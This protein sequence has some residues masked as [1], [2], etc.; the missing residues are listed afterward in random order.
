[1]LFRSRRLQLMTQIVQN[2]HMCD[3]GTKEYL[4]WNVRGPETDKGKQ[5]RPGD[6]KQLIG[7]NY[8]D[9]ET[10]TLKTI[11]GDEHYLI[12]KTIKIRSVLHC[13]HPDPSGI[14]STCFGELSLSV[15]E[16]TNIGQMCCTSLAQ[17]S[18]QKVISIK[19][20]DG[21]SVVDGI[22]LSS[23]DKQFLKVAVDDNSYL[24]AERLKSLDTKMIIRSIEANNIT[25]VAHVK[26]V[27]DLNIT[28]ISELT[29]ITF[30]TKVN[31]A[32]HLDIVDVNIGR[33]LASMTYDLL[34]YVKNN[35][36]DVDSDGNFI[37]D[38]KNWDWSKTILTLPLRH[39][40]MSDHNAEIADMIESSV[41]NMQERDSVVSPDA[42]IVEFFDLVN[43]KLN[44]NLAPLEVVMYA[45]MIVS[46]LNGDYSLPK[47]WTDKGLGI[48][49]LTIPRRSL[50]AAYAYEYHRQTIVNAAS[51]FDENRES[52]VM[53]AFIC[54]QEVIDD[55]ES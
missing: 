36:W 40:N 10:N 48:T 13:A 3:C 7:K 54:P 31:D 51:F 34:D 14:C 52:H 11:T 21:S 8:L 17:K 20:L 27:I 43:L 55:L 35:G 1:M 53:D 42:A 39:F 37:I 44:V 41:D 22:V 25:D 45:T 38:M 32:V 15:P 26:D 29:A 18:S 30:Q 4:L 33:R 2:L 19:H 6:L 46:A 49:S 5:Y 28:R 9:E 47:P 12:G 50:S 23:Y 24:L 16:N